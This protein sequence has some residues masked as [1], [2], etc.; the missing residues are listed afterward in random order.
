M[1]QDIKKDLELL[2]LTT[3]EPWRLAFARQ[4]LLDIREGER[5]LEE[6]RAARR[7]KD[8]HVEGIIFDYDKNAP[9]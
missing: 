5:Q 7:P 2:M 1:A 6:I 8:L 9:T 4:L 3:D